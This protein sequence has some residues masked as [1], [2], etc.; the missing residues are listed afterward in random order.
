[1]KRIILAVL[2]VVAAGLLQNTGLFSVWGVKP[3]LLLAVMI[4]VSLFIDSF[5]WYL[6]LVVLSVI[7]SR[8]EA[9]FRPE[10]LV[11]SFLL[12]AAYGVRRL[13]PWRPSVANCFLVAVSVILFYL[14]ADAPYLFGAPLVVVWEIIYSTLF[15]V[16]VY[17]IFRQ[18]GDNE[19]QIFRR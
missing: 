15:C 19:D 4:A 12:I 11:F 1:M 18:L 9:G 5:P 13:L 2:L 7:L 3:N 8:F 6:L 10:L 16:L 17:D 14:L